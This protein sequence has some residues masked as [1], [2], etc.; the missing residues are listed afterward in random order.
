MAVSFKLNNFDFLPLSFSTV[1]NPVSSVPASLSFATAC[2]SFS[3][4]SALSHKSLS[5]PANDCDGIV[6]SSNVYPSK[7]I[8]PSKSLVFNPKTAW[9]EG[10]GGGQFDP[11][12]GFSKNVSSKESEKLFLKFL[13]FLTLP[14]YKETNDVS[15]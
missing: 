10:G 5:D 1:S 14:C 13:D 7:P 11:P 8:R 9:E 4:V 3:N 12:C 15:L 6:C 2:S